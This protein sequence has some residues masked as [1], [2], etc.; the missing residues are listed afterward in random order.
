MHAYINTMG[1]KLLYQ[2]IKNIN[3]YITMKVLLAALRKN[4]MSFNRAVLNEEEEEEERIRIYKAPRKDYDFPEPPCS[5][6]TLQCFTP[7]T[8][9]E[10]LIIIKKSHNK[11]FDLDAFRTLLPKSC[12]N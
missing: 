6:N 8:T 12:I 3:I 5:K 1:I 7:A 10:V 11:S 4:R 2:E 9:N